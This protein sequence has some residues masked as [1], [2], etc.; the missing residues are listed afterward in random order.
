MKLILGQLQLS[1]GSEGHFSNL[2][3]VLLVLALNIFLFIFS[4]LLNLIK[5][6]LIVLRL[7]LNFLLK[8]F[9]L[10][11]L[12]FHKRAM[13]IYD[14][15][16]ILVVRLNDISNNF[17]KVSHLFLLLCLQFLESCS[18]LKHFLGVSIPVLV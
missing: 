4:I 14:A 2:L 9:S 5:N 1:L 16:D 15:I 17:F 11:N 10:S 13:L 7:T 3:L 12:L 8:L 18:I 6:F